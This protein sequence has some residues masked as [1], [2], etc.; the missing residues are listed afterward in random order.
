[1]ILSKSNLFLSHAGK[2]HAEIIPRNVTRFHM[3][4]CLADYYYWQ[5]YW[6]LNMERAARRASDPF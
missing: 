1:M 3:K 2:E 5:I 6:R 4:T